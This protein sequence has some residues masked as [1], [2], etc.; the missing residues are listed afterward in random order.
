MR[1]LQRSSSLS[2]KSLSERLYDWR[3]KNDFSQS[4]AALKLKVSKRTLQEWE[5]GG[6][7]SRHLVIEA[8]RAV[9]DR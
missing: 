6:A 5:H 7:E 3:E 9:I 8:I 1:R 4:E 2:R